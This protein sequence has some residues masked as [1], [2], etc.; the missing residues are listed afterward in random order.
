MQCSILST[1]ATP[2]GG[3]VPINVH[4]M[5][6]RAHVKCEAEPL[7]AWWVSCGPEEE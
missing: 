4:Q 6:Q 3:K 1:E 7:D 5:A 2:G